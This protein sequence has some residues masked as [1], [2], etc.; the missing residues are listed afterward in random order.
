M[1]L[2]ERFK[3]GSF[4]RDLSKD[5]ENT[6]PVLSGEAVPEVCPLCGKPTV[7]QIIIIQGVDNTTKDRFPAEW[8]G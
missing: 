2:R 5:S 4:F 7:K 1:R 6:E 3:N 8:K